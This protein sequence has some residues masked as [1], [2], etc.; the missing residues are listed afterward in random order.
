MKT[1]E[2]THNLGSFMRSQEII[3][4]Q[5]QLKNWPKKIIFYLIKSL[6]LCDI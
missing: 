3:Q 6:R 4:D 2:I 1:K 5:N